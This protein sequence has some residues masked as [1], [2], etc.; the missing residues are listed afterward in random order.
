MSTQNDHYI[1]LI[2]K[3]LKILRQ[4]K[5]FTKQQLAKDSGI[6]YQSIQK[7]EKGKNFPDESKIKIA[8]ALGIDVKLF[9]DKDLQTKIIDAINV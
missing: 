2:A 7:Y 5:N 9:F 6:L 1:E 4:L 3:N 8:N